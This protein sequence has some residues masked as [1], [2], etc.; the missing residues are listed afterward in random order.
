[1]II[2]TF[3]N[4][5]DPFELCGKDNQNK[6]TFQLEGFFVCESNAYSNEAMA[7]LMISMAS[8]SSASVMTKGGAKR[9]MC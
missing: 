4:I 2:D 7:F 8:R 9:M 3:G 5:D 1:M 6:K